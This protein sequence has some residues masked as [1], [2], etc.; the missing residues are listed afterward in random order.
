M[1]EKPHTSL[2]SKRNG[3]RLGSDGALYVDSERLLVKEGKSVEPICGNG[4]KC[5]C[6]RGGKGEGFEG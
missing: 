3:R 1:F 6:C 4:G 2:W 5:M